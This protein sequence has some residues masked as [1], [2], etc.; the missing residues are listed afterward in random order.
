MRF[1]AYFLGNQDAQR[2]NKRKRRKMNY[3][4]EHMWALLLLLLHLLLLM[5]MYLLHQLLQLL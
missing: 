2:M 3:R 4:F 5:Q 1:D